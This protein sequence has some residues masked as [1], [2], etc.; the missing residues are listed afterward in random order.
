MARAGRKV[1][2][3]DA[4]VRGGNVRTI[5]R[6]DLARNSE[7]KQLDPSPKSCSGPGNNLKHG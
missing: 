6:Y 7:V 2:Y 5:L 1:Q 4:D 3:I